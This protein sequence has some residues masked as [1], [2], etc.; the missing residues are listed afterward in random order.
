M[1][2]DVPAAGK[3][4]PCLLFFLPGSVRAL[5]GHHC[6]FSLGLPPRPGRLIPRASP[7]PRYSFTRIESPC[8]SGL[9][10][11]GE[12]LAD[13]LWLWLQRKPFVSCLGSL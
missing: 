9:I 5:G 6:V 2:W 4:A 11:D 3:S 7:D 10:T 8:Q 1:S 13:A 12:S